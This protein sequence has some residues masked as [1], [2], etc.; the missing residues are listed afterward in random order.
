MSEVL[1]KSSSNTANENVSTPRTVRSEPAL[2]ESNLRTLQTIHREL[3]AGVLPDAGELRTVGLVKGSPNE[4]VV[5]I[6][7]QNLERSAK[8]IFER[9]NEERAVVANDKTSWVKSAA[10]TYGEV[11]ALH[12]FRDGNDVVAREFIVREG[13]LAGF[14]VNFSAVSV[15]AWESASIEAF[16]GNTL[17][18]RQVFDQITSP[19]RERKN[20]MMQT[21]ERNSLLN[22]NEPRVTEQFVITSAQDQLYGSTGAK[23]PSGNN[24]SLISPEKISSRVSGQVL[25]DTPSSFI[26]KT[27][28]QEAVVIDKVTNPEL[29]LEKG[30]TVSFTR[31]GKH[32]TLQKFHQEPI[33][34]KDQERVEPSRNAINLGER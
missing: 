31:E 21:S 3:Y 20:L 17:V 28:P 4:R 25:A 11:N 8:A 19:M 6:D 12:P 9:V 27:S 5:F 15:K 14:D 1:E 22:I 34:I 33:A 10:Q 2:Q 30:D 29:K 13:K 24:L 32:L 26:V 16:K 7:P 23:I 18:V